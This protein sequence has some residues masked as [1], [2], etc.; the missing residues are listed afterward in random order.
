MIS[1]LAN[2]TNKKKGVLFLEPYISGKDT[3]HFR[4]NSIN[5]RDSF[6]KVGSK[7]IEIHINEKY[8]SLAIDDDDAEILDNFHKEEYTKINEFF[9]N[10]AT[11]KVELWIK[12]TE[13]K[14]LYTKEIIDSGFNTYYK[15]IFVYQLNIILKKNYDTFE[16]TSKE[17]IQKVNLSKYKKTE[18]DYGEFYIIPLKDI[19]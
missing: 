14:E 10:L 2:T 15:K 4:V 17:I 5:S 12:D 1:I 19:K 16:E 9:K 11:K 8:Y 13:E 3:L 6:Y 7:E 18:N